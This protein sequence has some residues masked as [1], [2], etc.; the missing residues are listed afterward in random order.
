MLKTLCRLRRTD[1][2]W[3][4]EN[5]GEVVGGRDYVFRDSCGCDYDYEICVVIHL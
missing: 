4:R 5:H 2:L 3:T 1:E